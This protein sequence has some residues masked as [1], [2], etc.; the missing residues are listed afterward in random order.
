MNTINS[1]PFQI[2]KQLVVEAWKLVKANAGSAGVDEESI[3]DFEANLKGN[4]YKLW[5]RM[6]SGSY[7]PPPVKEWQ[8]R[9]RM[10]DK[11]YW[12]FRV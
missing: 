6:S 7:M 8:Y 1:K 3:Q 2:S 4:L 10:A 9:R 11:G 5:N 12:E